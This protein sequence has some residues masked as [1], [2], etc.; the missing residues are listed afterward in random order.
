MI[1][2]LRCLTALLV[3]VCALAPTT[4]PAAEPVRIGF[5]IAKTGP[6]GAPSASQLQAYELWREQVNA[7]GGLQVGDK[8]KRP[9]EFVVYDDQSQGPTAARIYEKLITSDKV[10]LLL[11]P[12]ATALHM[13]ALPVVEKYKFPL[14]GNTVG[15]VQAKDLDAKYMFFTQP[16]PDQWADALVP[17]MKSLG[18]KR[19]AVITT[20]LQFTLDMKKFIMPQLEKTGFQVVFN[21]EYPADIKDMTTL[22]SGLKT[23]NPEF[24][25]GLSY[26]NDSVLYTTQARELG[27]SPTY[28][29]VMLGP[30]QASFVQRLGPNADG[31]ISL[32]MWSR[33]TTR[34]PK[35]KPFFE[36]YRARWQML[37]DDKDTT[38]AYVTCEVI[39]QAVAQ[40]GL[41]RDKLRN[42]L[43]SSTFDTIMGPVRYNAKGHNTA[44][45]AGFI[46]IQDGVNEVVWPSDIA[47]AKVIKKPAWK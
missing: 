20:Q 30:A 28:Q 46:Q 18:V 43:L 38:I 31:I 42:A 24:V 8:G 44:L 2:S 27:F 25:V 32:G 13:A 4:A 45:P 34:W 12:Y 9:V 33:N 41:D 16:F 23:S 5:S 17:L 14:L 36:A 47:T 37:P 3:L 35:A 40:A 6:L 10:D 19:V 39:E 15:S 26:L 7:R 21:Q 29:F 11:A 1:T 22:I